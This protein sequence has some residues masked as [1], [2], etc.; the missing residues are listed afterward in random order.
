VKDEQEHCEAVADAI[1]SH[2]PGDTNIGK[3]RRRVADLIA[4]ERA[5]ARAEAL[6]ERAESAD[7]ASA[8]VDHPCPCAC[9]RHPGAMPMSLHALSCCSWP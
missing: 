1:V 6:G 9:H 2:D 3:W 5:A 8:T 7:M 4:R